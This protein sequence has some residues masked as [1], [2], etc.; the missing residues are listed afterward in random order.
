MDCS[1]QHAT[2]D[3][4]AASL[5]PLPGASAFGTSMPS[6]ALATEA[7]AVGGGAIGGG[8]GGGDFAGL[9]TLRG[10]ADGLFAAIETR[11]REAARREQ[12][13]DAVREQS[14]HEREDFERQC[15]EVRASMDIARELLQAERR[16]LED[17]KTRMQ[18]PDARRSDVLSLN[19]GGERVVQRRRSTLCAVEDSF[20]AARFSGRWEQELDLDE[21]GKYFINYPPELFLPLL[22]YLGA[23]ET[24]GPA[25]QLPLPLGPDGQRPQFQ[26]MLR[27]FGMLPAVSILDV[28]QIPYED[29]AGSDHGL[30]FEILP[31]NNSLMLVALETCAGRFVTNVAT[32]TVYICQGTLVRRLR[33][34]DEWRQAAVCSLRPGLSSR[35]EL[36]EPVRLQANCQHCVYIATNNANGIAYGGGARGGT[37]VCGENEDLCMYAARTSGSMVP[38]AGFEGFLYWHKFNGKLEYTLVDGI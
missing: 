28:L 17:E 14:R 29:V 37:D 30:A 27:Y 26:A 4:P 3:G 5:R 31:K 34:R 13:A 12:E 2:P 16:E 6:D 22:D 33:Q 7:G 23:K 21:D 32:A 36:S 9:Q 35:I 25:R 24:E 8:V 10:S 20:L 18:A 1:G 19:V 11:L 15:A 38:F